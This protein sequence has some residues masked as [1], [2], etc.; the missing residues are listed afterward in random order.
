LVL[1]ALPWL[2]PYLK[3]MELPGGFK[4]ELKD[5]KDAL[6]QIREGSEELVHLELK[7]VTPELSKQ[8]NLLK[9]VG[10]KDPN[11]MLIGFRIEI[12]KRILELAKSKGLDVER[13]PL[14]SLINE[15][16]KKQVLLPPVA[17]GLIEIVLLGNQA[18]HGAQVSSDA[19]EWVLDFGVDVLKSLDSLIYNAK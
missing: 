14:H 9:E 15:L 3:S 10:G 12:E 6:D 13:V 19:A 11:L 4:I 16:Q 5:I 17:S 7:E 2:L 8:I 18:A 1:A